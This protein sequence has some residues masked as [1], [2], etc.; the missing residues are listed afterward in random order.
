MPG[1]IAMLAGA[2]LY[3]QNRTDFFTLDGQG[4]AWNKLEGQWVVVNYFAEWCAPCLKEIPELNGFADAARS[5]DDLAMFAVS[6]DALSKEELLVLKEKY[7]MT[8]PLIAENAEQLP[9]PKPQQLPA[10]Y[11]LSPQGK[12]VKRLLGEQTQVSLLQAIE[13]LKAQH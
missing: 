3:Q 10:T 8:F 7:A 13:V 1:V 12:I 6:W 5:R 9:I 2:W 11:V 4:H